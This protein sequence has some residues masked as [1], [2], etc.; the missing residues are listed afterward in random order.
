MIEA[1]SGQADRGRESSLDG[2]A[3]C[4]GTA[5]AGSSLALVALADL[6][7]FRPWFAA[8]AILLAV[9][10]SLA[11]WRPLAP[12]APRSSWA[13][14]FAAGIL[15]GAAVLIAP[16]SENIAGPRDPGV[17]VATAFAIARG[18][19]TLEED[20]GLLLLRETI[21]AGETNLW[22]YH[23]SINLA[24][25]RYPGQLF[26][27]DVGAGLVE[28]SF[29]PVL[30][31][32]MALAASLGGL[33]AALHVS[34]VF[35]VLALA[36]AML[37]SRA[38]GGPGGAPTPARGWILVGALLATSFSQVWWARE[39]MAESALGTF[40]WLAAW[41]SIQWVRLGG[42]R[43]A[44]LAGLA[45]T[46]ALFTRADG[47]LIVA[48]VGLSF[49][50]LRGRD[51]WAVLALVVPGTIAFAIHGALR[52][53]IYMSTVYGAFTAERAALGI[54]AVGL[55]GAI[56]LAASRLAWGRRAA[57][58][59]AVAAMAASLMTGVAPGVG[60]DPGLGAASPLAWLPGYVPWPLLVLAAAG[61]VL[62]GWRG[63]P[64]SSLPL[65]LMGGLPTLLFLIDP[66][67]TGDHPWMVRRLVPLV[68]PFLAMLAAWAAEGMFER[69]GALSRLRF[70]GPTL[71]AA[72]VGTGLGLSAAMLV[73]LVA[74]PR[75]GAG[76]VSGLVAV[77]A[78][79]EEDAVIVF[80]ASDLGTQL[81]M[82]LGA[83][84]GVTTFAIPA[85][86]LTPEVA[87]TLQRWEARGVPVYWAVESG[88]TLSA[89]TGVEA[90]LM[91]ASR[92]R[93]G[94][95]DGG[96]VPPPLRMTIYERELLLFRVTFR[97]GAAWP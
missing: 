92:L 69:R 76:I 78:A 44:A 73:D 27:R 55:A 30:P 64:A 21:D 14:T 66:L 48:A 77:R 63:A 93:W 1:P 10:L 15:L 20:R 29:L 26:V 65:V 16:G 33:E 83:T 9:A 58:L 31:V 23:S 32:W 25:V 53:P 62:L 11:V 84:S 19:G 90:R 59:L 56:L 2:W 80:P 50:A 28:A 47:I 13:A 57:T 61:V 43:W 4:L 85:P 8:A 37:A 74:A 22:L 86:S 46:A 42:S 97:T 96:P 41:A 95:A 51:R 5:V 49:L 40:G 67:V 82:P 24:P 7:W 35:G 38:A 6:G 79:V 17:Y 34:G 60:R 94:S 81:A 3:A 12:W 71:A 54:V 91:A 52:A 75:H 36:C 45:A 39:P 87:A 72:L 18:G 70:A 68:I 89:P 88:D